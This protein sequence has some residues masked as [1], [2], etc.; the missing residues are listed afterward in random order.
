[1]LRVAS[2]TKNWEAGHNTKGG[3]NIGVYKGFAAV[4]QEVF[5]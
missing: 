4:E 2:D 5:P 1:M 3:D